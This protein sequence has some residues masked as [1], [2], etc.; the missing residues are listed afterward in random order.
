MRR[1]SGQL[2]ALQPLQSMMYVRVRAMPPALDFGLGLAERLEG[3]ANL[4]GEELRLLPGSEV[5]SLVDLVEVDDVRVARLDPAARS[6][7]DLARKRR[8]AERHRRWRQ[9]LGAPALCV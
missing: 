2:P 9:R 7:P 1:A 8:E 3:R 4:G 6:P 5:A